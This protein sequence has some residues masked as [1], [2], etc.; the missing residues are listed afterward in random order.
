MKCTKPLPGLCPLRRL[1][2]GRRFRR[3]ARRGRGTKIAAGV[4]ARDESG[5]ASSSGHPI[6]MSGSA[7]L[8]VRSDSFVESLRL[9]LRRR[10]QAGP[11]SK[12]GRK[13]LGATRGA[14]ALFGGG[15]GPGGIQFQRGG[16]CFR[17]LGGTGGRCVALQGV[18]SKE[19]DV[20]IEEISAAATGVQGTRARYFRLCCNI[21]TSSSPRGEE[22]SG[23]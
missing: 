23:G 10:S 20:K 18:I 14:E 19:L 11:R 5:S 12:K 9:T 15:E 16:I 2:W 6:L 13:V 7:F 22:G 3:G 17:P 8:F 4:S 21:R 1:K